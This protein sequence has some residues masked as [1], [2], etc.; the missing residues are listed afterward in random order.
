MMAAITEREA[1]L[2]EITNQVI[3]HGPES[4]EEKLDELQT[5][6]VAR[7]TSLRE[8]IVNPSAVHEGE[9]YWLSRSESSPLSKFKKA[10]RSVSEPA[11]R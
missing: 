3:E 4:L 2:R 1:R 10:V 7:L 11:V 5:F 8:L 6:A 9:R